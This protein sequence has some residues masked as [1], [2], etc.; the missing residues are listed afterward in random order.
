MNFCR[1]VKLS[2]LEY[3]I[4]SFSY[5]AVLAQAFDDWLFQAYI[6]NLSK[7]LGKEREAEGERERKGPISRNLPK[8]YFNLKE[9]LKRSYIV[10]R[11]TM[12]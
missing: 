1:I 5:F 10:Q 7:M 9:S 3:P 6:N 8:I 11:C 4:C 12:C 2:R